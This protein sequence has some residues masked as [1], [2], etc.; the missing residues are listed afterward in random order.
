VLVWVW[1][2]VGA[3]SPSVCW[4]G[5]ASE[6][7]VQ[8]LNRQ[9]RS[10]QI[11]PCISCGTGPCLRLDPGRLRLDHRR[12]TF[13]RSLSD[14]PPDLEAALAELGAETLSVFVESLILEARWAADV[15]PDAPKA[16]RRP[17]Q[18]RRK[19]Q[20]PRAPARPAESAPAKPAPAES[21]PAESAPAQPPEPEPAPKPSPP[22][23]PAP[24]WPGGGV[25]ASLPEGL[26][27]ARFSLG[28]TA[29]VEFR[30]PGFVSPTVGVDVQRSDWVARARFGVLGRWDWEDRP[31]E[32][33]SIGLEGGY[34]PRW[35]LGRHAA[36]WAELGMGAELVGWRRSDRTDGSTWGPLGFAS[37]GLGLTH[38]FGPFELGWGARLWGAP[39][40]VALRAGIDGPERTVGRWGIRAGLFGRWRP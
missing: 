24:P 8:A 27:T 9:V 19:V 40:G 37:A 5:P 28:V 30:S 31:L 11:R 33:R 18:S 15:E 39:W 26:G 20:A 3:A 13:T 35:A 4:V 34:R 1:L 14:A 23:R 22:L 2:A 6:G 7:S 36:V 32:L 10:A 16:R 25:R 29:G 38:L 17:G 21:A 12:R